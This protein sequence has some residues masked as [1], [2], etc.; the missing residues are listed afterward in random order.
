MEPTQLG[1]STV[2]ALSQARAVSLARRLLSGAGRASLIAYDLAS[3]AEAAALAHGLSDTGDLLVA[4][5]ADEEIP[6]TTW[7][8]APLR[9]RFDIVKEAPEWSVR[10]ISCAVHL[11]GVLEWL[12]DEERDEHLARG[13]PSRLAELASAPGGR[14]GVIRAD[15]ILLHDCSGVTPLAFEEVS[16]EVGV[17]PDLE[18]EWEARE[19]VAQL[20]PA[21]LSELLTAAAAGWNAATV[22]AGSST[23]SCPHVERQVFCVD[24]DRTGLTVMD[25]EPGFTAVVVFAFAEP[26]DT[27]AELADGLRQLLES[28]ATVQRAS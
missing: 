24:V 17:F 23:G 11:L 7:R 20:A 22:L 9:V 21:E 25:V 14:L 15:R 28:A 2:H 18:S 12:T 3:S 10:I 5:I 19:L 8:R 27:M 6:A 4:G 1:V 13:L 26:A 16:D